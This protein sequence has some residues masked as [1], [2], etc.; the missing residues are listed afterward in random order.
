[1]NVTINIRSFFFGND[2]TVVSITLY[3]NLYLNSCQLFSFYFVFEI[4]SN[5][6]VPVVEHGYERGRT[7]CYV[8]GQFLT[9]ATP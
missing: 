2:Q 8:P 4:E 1:M 5:L 9:E 6:D 3:L 7:S